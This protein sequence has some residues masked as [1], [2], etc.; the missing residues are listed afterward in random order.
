MTSSARAVR[1]PGQVDQEQ[2]E[3]LLGVGFTLSP[4]PAVLLDDALVITA[5]NR[6]AD[7]MLGP[8][9]GPGPQALLGRC[10]AD[11][12][13]PETSAQFTPVSYTHLTL[14]TKRIV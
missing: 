8:G 14:P 12:S 5:A 1:Q 13:A 4:L 6:S 9:P 3:D 10:I 2:V 11:F 7:L